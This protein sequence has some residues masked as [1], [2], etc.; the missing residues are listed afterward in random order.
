[1]NGPA[2]DGDAGTAPTKRTRRR[3]RRS[4]VDGDGA[5]DTVGQASTAPDMDATATAT[6]TNTPDGAAVMAAAPRT[7][8]FRVLIDNEAPNAVVERILADIESQL[9]RDIEPDSFWLEP[10]GAQHKRVVVRIDLKDEPQQQA[11]YRKLQ[12]IAEIHSLDG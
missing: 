12:A 6:L 7:H 8:Q 2:A 3:R 11:I 4:R 1:M 5:S 9:G 10:A